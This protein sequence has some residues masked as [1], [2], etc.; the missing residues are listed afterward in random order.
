MNKVDAVYL[1]LK[2]W[3]DVL[4]SL[5]H[6]AEKPATL[7]SL[8][9][10]IEE[11]I[12]ILQHLRDLFPIG[13]QHQQQILFNMLPS[14]WG[15]DRI[16]K[17]FGCSEY[18]ARQSAIFKSNGEVLSCVEDGRGNKP[19]DDPTETL[20]KNF[21]T[22]DEVSRETSNKKQVIHPPPSRDPVPLRFLHL[23]I[24]ETFEKFKNMYPNTIVGRSKFYSLRPSWVKEKTPHES[25]L[26]IQ[27]SNADL[28][29][30][31]NNF[32]S[33]HLSQF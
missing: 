13:N 5:S 16:E 7:S 6:C 17:W 32:S 9:L 10:T 15:R 31:V 20:I 33:L 8:D 19:L 4:L 23:T 2:E 28:L 29:L 22:S 21:Y 12:T 24:G 11:A 27:H 18:Q 26:C 30:Q 3:M 14:S 25:C 1:Q